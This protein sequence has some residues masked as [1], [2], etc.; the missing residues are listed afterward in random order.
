MESPIILVVEDDAAVRRGIVDCLRASGY[1]VIEAKDGKEGMVQAL[2]A[3]YSLMLL[4][5]VMP[6]ATG[7]D[8]LEALQKKR[9][10]QAVIILSAK[11]EEGDR[12]KGLSMGADDYVMK[13]FS[14]RELLARVD[15]VLRRTTE[16]QKTK[17]RFS[18]DSGT[19]DFE[20]R[21]IVYADGER[22]ELSERESSLLAY[23]VTNS[24]RAIARD[25]LLRQVWQIDPKNIETRTVDMHI[26]NLRMK[27][28]DSKEAP[29]ILITVRGKGY[30][31]GQ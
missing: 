29:E 1:Q 18:F 8:I 13:P 3:N 2:N 31:I 7:F 25:E 4:D 11:G 19:A 27:L 15:A 17:D 12:V 5:L 28:R 26:A 16:R 10:G 23:L 6:Y 14:I 30:M 24:G 21:E 9:S 20:R 22:S